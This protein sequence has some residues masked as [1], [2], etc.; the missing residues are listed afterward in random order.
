LDIKDLKDF[1]RLLTCINGRSVNSVLRT[2]LQYAFDYNNR[3][4]NF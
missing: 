4:T 1:E 2:V 3:L